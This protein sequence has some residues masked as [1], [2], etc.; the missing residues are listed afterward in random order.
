MTELAPEEPLDLDR[1]ARGIAERGLAVP[2]VFFLELHRPLAH[3][4]SELALIGSPLLASLLGLRR[5][6]QLRAVLADPEQY[7]AL[8][9]SIERHAAEEKR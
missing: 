1:L 3:L 8:V 2:A 7:E 4:A 9:T 6:E 5:F